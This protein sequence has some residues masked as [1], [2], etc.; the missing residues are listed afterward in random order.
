VWENAAQFGW[1]PNNFIQGLTVAPFCWLQSYI[2]P[3]A[4]QW[5]SFNW[6]FW[7][8]PAFPQGSF[9]MTNP[10]FFAISVNTKQPDL[11]WELV[12]WLTVQPDWQRILMRAVLL[13]P[14]YLPLWDEWTTVVKQV[15][16]TLASKNLDV[17]A[18]HVQLGIMYGGTD[19][20]YSDPQAKSLLQ[21]WYT[22][23]LNRTV[24]VQEGL[25]Q[26]AQQI[27]TLQVTAAAEAGGR[28]QAA[29]SSRR[30]VRPW[31]RRRRA[32]RNRRW[33]N[34]PNRRMD[35]ILQEV[36]RRLPHVDERGR[37]EREETVESELIMNQRVSGHGGGGNAGGP[38]NCSRAA[39]E[40][41]VP[42]PHRRAQVGLGTTPAASTGA[43]AE[44][45]TPCSPGGGNGHARARRAP[46]TACGSRG[47]AR[48][49]ES[50]GRG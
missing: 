23:I 24:T 43:P 48:S 5:K 44:P 16:P 47:A 27:D 12:E 6:D 14:G 30:R 4:T 26:C 17:F 13:P 50:R 38:R 25:A 31:L 35:A 39:D 18:Q 42:R 7:P 46:L 28:R 21:G 40:L 29:S 41:G 36:R 45:E 8:M 2:I 32:S 19:F 20:A 10:N 37:Q 3:A 15:A 49:R 34:V 33:D 22:K 11:A 9:A 1:V